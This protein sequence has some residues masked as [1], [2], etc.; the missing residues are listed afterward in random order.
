[1]GRGDFSKWG[2]EQLPKA[3]PFSHIYRPPAEKLCARERHRPLYV[4]PERAP[5]SRFLEASRAVTATPDRRNAEDVPEAD[6]LKA[7]KLVDDDLAVPEAAR[8]LSVD[9]ATLDRRHTYY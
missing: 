8:Q 7:Y 4:L 9:R 3:V 2:F 6:W 1:M 5:R